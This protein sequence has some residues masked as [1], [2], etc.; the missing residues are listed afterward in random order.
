MGQRTQRDRGS[1]G[2]LLSGLFLVAIL[3]LVE[4]PV[5]AVQRQELGMRSRFAD[6]A[7]VQ[8]ENPVRGLDRGKPV[9]NA[10]CSGVREDFARGGLVE[11]LSLRIDARRGLV[12][13]ENARV[14]RKGT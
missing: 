13:H 7:F 2:P 1:V 14:I 6:L 3:K 8:D 9:G 5:D 12:E 4:A 11:E 10:Y